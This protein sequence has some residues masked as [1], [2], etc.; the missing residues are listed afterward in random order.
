MASSNQIGAIQL[1]LFIEKI[2]YYEEGIVEIIRNYLI[3]IGLREQRGYFSLYNTNGKYIIYLKTNSE[4]EVPCSYV[5]KEDI[6]IKPSNPYNNGRD[7]ICLKSNK[8]YHKYYMF[9]PLNVY[10]VGVVDKFVRIQNDN[11]YNYDIKKWNF[12]KY[13]IRK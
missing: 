2:A 8:T 3:G 6:V 9:N 13:I 11:Y 4:I 7:L 5:K 1:C 10:Y 12:K